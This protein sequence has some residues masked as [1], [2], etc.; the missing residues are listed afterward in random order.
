MGDIP[1]VELVINYT[2]PLTIEDMVHRTGRTGRAGKKGNAVTF[3]N[4]NGDHKEKEHVFDLVQLLEGAKQ[5][6]PADLKNLNANTFTATKKKKHGMYGD[7]FKTEEEM[8]KLSAKKM[9]VT[10]SDSE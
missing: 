8:A 6:V 5:N 4:E 9:Q 1:D 3:F 10:F 7:F 2:F